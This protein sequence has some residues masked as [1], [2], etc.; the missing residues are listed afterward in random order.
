MTTTREVER[1]YAP[2]PGAS[3]PDLTAVPGIGAVSDPV[4]FTLEATYF[5]TA[6]L[7]LAA[8]R[9]TLRRRYGGADEGWHLKLPAGG[10]RD[11][12]HAP[13][14]GPATEPP[15]ELAHLVEAFSRG[16]PLVPVG[17]IVTERSRRLLSGPDGEPLA[18][19]VDDQVSAQ[20]LGAVTTVSS[21]REAEVELAGGEESLLDAIEEHLSAAGIDRAK[22]PSKLAQLLGDRIPPRP[23][24]PGTSSTTAEAGVGYLREQL[25]TLLEY[26]PRVRLDEHDAV[27]KMR[28]A[29]RR[30]R[31]A[32]KT[33]GPALSPP[34][35]L[36][37]ELRWL[38]GELGAVRDLD[39][40]PVTLEDSLSGLPDELVVGP[41]RARIHARTAQDRARARERLLA[42]LGS[43]RYYRLLG[44]LETFLAD[45][46]DSDSGEEGLPTLVRRAYKRV[47]KRMA[48]AL[49]KPPG[50][51]KDEAI[52]ETR[53]AVKRARYAGEAAAPVLGKHAKKFVARMQELQEVLG[54]HQDSVVA[55]Q[56]LRTLGMQAFLAGENSFTYGLLYGLAAKTAADTERELPA[57]WSRL[58]DPW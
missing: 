42:S 23:E 29:T 13:L 15:A 9:V 14:E 28:V 35:E 32:L 17:R 37:E 38:G 27:H 50:T 7:R 52:H 49:D 31:S 12:I 54:A 51:G 24:P 25:A 16:E 3:L 47:A 4:T 22:S 26:D 33:F 58:G 41:V 39:V 30:S 1:K 44:A 34:E 19:A 8:N 20:S 21:W 36:G 43:D 45:V 18:E 48:I 55:R 40:L 46:P 5:D 56:V 11:E 57:E 2:P 10:A 6:G 53:K